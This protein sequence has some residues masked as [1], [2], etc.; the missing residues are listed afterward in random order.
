M[1]DLN[2]RI[3]QRMTGESMIFRAVD[4]TESNVDDTIHE[5]TAEFMETLNPPSLPPSILEL[6]IGT[7]LMLMRNLHPREGLC[8]GTRMVVT[9]L[10]Q[11]CVQARIVG[12]DF[13]GNIHGLFRVKLSSNEGDF[14][15]ILTR[16][17]FPVRPC[18]AITIN[19]AQGQSLETVGIDL[20]RPC[21][22]H[23]QLYVAYSRATD[24]NKL[25]ILQDEKDNGF[26]D[27]VVYPEVLM[28]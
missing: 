5:L 11:S 17:Q 4:Q 9:K 12:G 22:S 19:K 14:P 28:S 23:G 16:N 21:F 2:S 26:T 10:H 1:N 25:S 8:N 13:D 3:L 18:F 7:P 6:K 27:N 20:R 24:M 15:W